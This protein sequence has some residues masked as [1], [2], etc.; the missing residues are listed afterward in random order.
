MKGFSILGFLQTLIVVGLAI[1]ILR[2]FGWDPIA[3]LLWVADKLWEIVNQ[4][5]DW[6]TGNGTFRSLFR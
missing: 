5:A 3:A 4:I 6:F 1:A 2:V